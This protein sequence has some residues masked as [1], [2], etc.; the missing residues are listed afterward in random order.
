MKSHYILRARACNKSPTQH[1]YSL[2][3]STQRVY[4]VRLFVV[5]ARTNKRHQQCM[6]GA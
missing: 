6:I 4:D 1:F 3:E 2:V 5:S